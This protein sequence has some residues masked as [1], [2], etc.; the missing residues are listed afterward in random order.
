MAKIN[1]LKM[2][3]QNY[4]KSGFAEVQFGMHN[5]RGIFGAAC[6]GEMFH[7]ISLG[8]FKY[9]L[10]AFSAQAGPKSLALKQ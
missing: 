9:R 5:R 2:L 3:S 8:W 4:L 7:L 1:K 6:P 10:E